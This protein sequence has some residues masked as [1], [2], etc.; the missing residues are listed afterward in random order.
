M[1]T[2]VV[3][4]DPDAPGAHLDTLVP[5]PLSADEAAALSIAMLADVCETV[6]RGEA[7][8]L[9]NYATDPATETEGTDKESAG[10][11]GV[12]PETALREHLGPEL[13]RPDAVRYE[14]QVGSTRAA[15]V[16]NAVTHLLESEH[17]QMVAVV[18]PRAAFLRREHVGS[19]A[20]KL[21]SSEVLL[22]PT[23]GGGV[24]FAGFT[25]PIDF[26][27][28]YAR[29][30]VRTLAQRADTAGLDVDFLPMTPVV[31]GSAA[32]ETAVALLEARRVAGRLVPPR[33]T[34]R[35]EQLGLTI[36]DDG[37]VTRTGDGR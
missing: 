10:N 8:L 31:D 19:A 26:D 7:D 37:T 35:I 15:R 24:Y 16:G 18:D 36:G 30:A 23:P 32:L 29:P 3:L 14:P 17:E 9:V 21:R 4:A 1:T 34:A 25:A 33:T 5:D 28:A 27:D 2:I 13:P 12:D 22:G 11:D 6:Q 20:M